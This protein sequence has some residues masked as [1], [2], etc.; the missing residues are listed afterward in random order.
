MDIPQLHPVYLQPLLSMEELE[1]ITVMDSDFYGWTTSSDEDVSVETNTDFEEETDFEIGEEE[2]QNINEQN[3]SETGFI[4]K[5]GNN[6]AWA[7]SKLH[8]GQKWI[9]QQPACQI[10]KIAAL[11][12]LSTQKDSFLL[13][14]VQGYGIID[15]PY[16][17]TQ[18]PQLMENTAHLK[19][20]VAFTAYSIALKLIVFEVKSYICEDELPLAREL[21]D[22]LKTE[23]VA[24]ELFSLTIPLVK[25]TISAVHK[26]KVDFSEEQLEKIFPVIAAVLADIVKD[27]KAN[28]NPIDGKIITLAEFLHDSKVQKNLIKITNKLITSYLQAYHN[29]LC[30]EGKKLSVFSYFSSLWKTGGVGVSLQLAGIYTDFIMR[31]TFGRTSRL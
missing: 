2:D 9:N 30:D 14:A 24:K 12:W 28:H 20:R 27:H 5:C 22:K 6:V 23:K 19:D 3:A 25:Q 1:I 13:N 10:A 17:L 18:F 4:R 26:L 11:L 21:L 8:N 7:A 31:K 16:V 29:V 15:L